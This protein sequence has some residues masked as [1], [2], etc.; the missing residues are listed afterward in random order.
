MYHS[1]NVI[2][3]CFHGFLFIYIKNW[4]AKKHLQIE[5]EPIGYG[6][7]CVW[8]LQ[9]GLIAFTCFWLYGGYIFS[10]V[11][12][13]GKCNSNCFDRKKK[14]DCLMRK[15][16][17]NLKFEVWTIKHFQFL[18]KIVSS[19]KRWNWNTKCLNARV[20]LELYSIQLN[21][22]LVI[23]QTCALECW[24]SASTSDIIVVFIS[25]RAHSHP[26]RAM[27]APM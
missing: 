23:M 6:F 1:G 19:I 27:F 8:K 5:I 14:I 11:F 21:E 24:E 10:I 17:N 2:V 26:L 16:S 7:D 12:R 22:H 13:I 18:R 4:N 15:V 20:S 3:P 25:M 9:I